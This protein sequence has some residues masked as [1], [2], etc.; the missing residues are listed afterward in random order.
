MYAIIEDSG[1]QFKVAEGERIDVDLRAA[2][3][4]DT[5]D[6]NHVL[7]LGGETRDV[8]FSPDGTV[9]YVANSGFNRLQ[10]V[11]EDPAS[12]TFHTRR[13][14]VGTVAR[15]GTMTFTLPAGNHRVVAELRAAPATAQAES[16]VERGL[17]LLAART[18]LSVHEKHNPSAYAASPLHAAEGTAR[19]LL[20]AE[21]GE[22]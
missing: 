14:E 2:K 1:R 19:T 3:A 6:F 15:R 21:R 13:A 8:A 22:R 11:D 4:G 7:F 17:R 9:S 20:D 5:L 18:P 10:V 12:A 16:E